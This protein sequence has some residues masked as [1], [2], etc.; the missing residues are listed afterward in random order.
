MVHLNIRS[1]AT[2]VALVLSVSVFAM[3]SRPKVEDEAANKRIA[4]V[5]RVALAAP[6]TAAAGGKRSGE[7]IY[8]AVCGACHEAGVARRA[9]ARRQ[10][11]LG[12]AHQDSALTA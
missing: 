4:P 3:G 10:R 12:A 6:A 5:A 1:L 9:Q 7:Q 8:K 11:R 2:A